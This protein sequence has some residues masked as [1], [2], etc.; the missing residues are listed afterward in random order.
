[1][2]TVAT[3]RSPVSV[4]C[5]MG[6]CSSSQK[7]AVQTTDVL[8]NEERPQKDVPA[9]TKKRVQALF[10][11]C[12]ID[13]KGQLKISQFKAAKMSVGPH[14]VGVFPEL[15]N[16]DLDGDGFI[17]ADEWHTWFAATHDAMGAAEF[18]DVMSEME[19]AAADIVVRLNALAASAAGDGHEEEVPVAPLA[20]ARAAAV[21]ELFKLWAEEH[22]ESG[23]L[24][25]EIAKMQAQ[26]MKVGPYE[27]RNIFPS[28]GD[29]D[30]NGDGLVELDEM[31]AYFQLVGAVLGDEEFDELMAV[32]RA[33]AEHAATVRR[34]VALSTEEPPLAPQ[35]SEQVEAEGFV[36]PPL[37]EARAAKVR[38]SR[39]ELSSA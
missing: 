27:Q 37:S 33:M 12:N 16:M 17:T 1:M 26:P 28:L 11:M 8:L 23:L 5:T 24:C 2:R 7:D 30:A 38:E 21:T 3:A 19:R 29:I 4:Y 22:P 32:G 13:G 20:P 39:A 35:G 34:C 15:E 14:T 9:A 31:L 18:D 6:C 36:P 10:E 25:I